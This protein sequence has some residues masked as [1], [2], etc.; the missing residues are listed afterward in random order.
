[1]LEVEPPAVSVAE[2]CNASRSTCAT[3]VWS[4]LNA[5]CL[6]GGRDYVEVLGGSGLD[7]SVMTRFAALCGL[8]EEPGNS[9]FHLPR[10]R[11]DSRHS[12]R[13]LTL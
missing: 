13:F 5:Q 7:T 11:N 2:N 6:P 3:R 12:C 10:L 9:T 4:V 1:M 8:Q